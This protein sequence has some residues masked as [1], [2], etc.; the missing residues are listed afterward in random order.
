MAVVTDLLFQVFFFLPALVYDHLRI[1]ENR[2]D[3]FCCAKASKVQPVRKDI[4]RTFF[5]KYFVPFVHRKTTKILVTVITGLMIVVG[6]MSCVK[7]LR[8]LN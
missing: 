3:V 7:I 1:K 2:Y 4:V 6:G 5:N 8:G